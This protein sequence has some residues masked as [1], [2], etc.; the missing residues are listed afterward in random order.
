MKWEGHEES[1][2]VEDRRR[3]GARGA[4]VGGGAV[5]VL[6]AA[7]FGV[8]P[9]TVNMLLSKFGGGAAQQP[10][11]ERQLSPEEEKDAKFHAVVLR[12]T[13]EVWDVHYPKLGRGA[14][15]HPKLS[16]FTGKVDTA[17]GSASSA[18]G[19]FYCPADKKVYI[20]PSFF[21]D[22]ERKLGGSKAK[23]S[24][25]YVIAHEVG[26]H[27]Q[28]LIGYNA[29]VN[30]KRNGPKEEYNRWS[31]KL[32]LQADYLAGVWA[33]YAQKKHNFMEVGDLDAALKSANAIGDDTLGKRSGGFVSP[34]GYTHGTS[35]QRVKWFRRGYETGD[36]S[37]VDRMFK[38][39]HDEL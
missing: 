23:F 11:K 2:N 8:S 32:E 20:D 39:N 26:H 33:H 10:G 9:D 35:E 18:V 37:M 14:Y 5:V 24:Q 16:L 36:L 34:Q 4:M 1:G 21:E 19:P 27:V 17:C 28:N 22:L 31:V 6:V 30:Q 38:M 13:E 12:W 3:F 7:L 25:A 15:Q 29:I